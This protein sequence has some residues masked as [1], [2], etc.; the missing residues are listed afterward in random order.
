[1]MTREECILPREV[2]DAL[3]CKRTLHLNPG[4]PEDEE[5]NDEGVDIRVRVSVTG[6]QDTTVSQENTTL[7][8]TNGT[9]SET[10]AI[11]NVR[12]SP[13]IPLGR[14]GEPIVIDDNKIMCSI[15]N[16]IIVPDEDR[17]LVVSDG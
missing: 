9:S 17:G 8:Q 7:E 11:P 10:T 6:T 14:R 12:H 1:M 15:C 16:K 4:Q 2:Y 13:V 5:T 3:E